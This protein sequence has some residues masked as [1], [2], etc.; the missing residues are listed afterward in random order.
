MEEEDFEGTL[1]LE[2]LAAYLA[3]PDLR[4]PGA[5]SLLFVKIAYEFTALLVGRAIYARSPQLDELRDVLKSLRRDS[6]AF[7]VEM[8]TAK[9]AAR[10][11]GSF[12]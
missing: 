6:D 5:D 12:A 3:G 2:K 4:A 7:Q 8:L 1:V 11:G 10:C 9:E